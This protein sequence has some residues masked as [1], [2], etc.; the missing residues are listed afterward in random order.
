MDISWWQGI[1]GA[2]EG[3]IDAYWCAT[4]ILTALHFL[5]AH[6]VSSWELLTFH[7]DQFTN[8]GGFTKYSTLVLFSV[9]TNSLKTS[10]VPLYTGCYPH[11]ENPQDNQ[12]KLG[13]C[14][15]ILYLFVNSKIIVAGMNVHPYSILQCV[16]PI[17]CTAAER[18]WN[19][20][21]F[22]SRTTSLLSQS[23]AFSL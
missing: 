8:C 20:C 3:Q 9:K 12:S 15:W 13:T 10:S 11:N 23:L 18:D 1:E 5:Q 19:I 16:E 17:P 7:F 6:Y 22:C 2:Y 4:V 21:C 14:Y